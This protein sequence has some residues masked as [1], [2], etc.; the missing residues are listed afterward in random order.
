MFFVGANACACFFM[1]KQILCNCYKDEQI[2]L[3]ILYNMKVKR[4]V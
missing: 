3:G 2:E 4:K 1:A